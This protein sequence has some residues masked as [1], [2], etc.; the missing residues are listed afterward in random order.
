MALLVW[1]LCQ[2]AA[3]MASRRWITR[4]VTPAG[5]RPR[6]LEIK[7]AFQCVVDGFNDLPQRFEESGPWAGFLALAG[8]TE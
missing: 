2:I 8:W 3:V 4:A 5:V 7:L 1:S 6:V